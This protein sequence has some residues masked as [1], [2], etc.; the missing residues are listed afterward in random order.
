[1]MRDLEE[2]VCLGQGQSL[3]LL[4]NILEEGGEH[5]RFLKFEGEVLHWFLQQ[6]KV[7][8]IFI[9]NDSVVLIRRR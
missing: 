8:A 5:H 4:D 7:C 3:L 6:G 2:V 1:M 9:Y